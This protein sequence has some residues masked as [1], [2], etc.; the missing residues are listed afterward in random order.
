MNRIALTAALSGLA[1]VSSANAAFN[2][3]GAQIVETFD[4]L[5]LSTVTGVFSATAGTQSVVNGTGFDGTRLGGTGTAT[6]D[7]TASDGSANSGGIY[8]FGAASASERALGTI[9]SGTNFM[10]FGFQLTNGTTDNI[11]TVSVRF[12]QENWRSSTSEVNTT[13]ASYSTTAAASTY[14]TTGTFTPAPLLDLVGP[15][16]VTTNGLLDGNL[17]ANQVARA[18]TITG[19]SIA[20]GASI[21]F[22]WQD[23]NNA[24]S[25]AGLAIDA[26]T[27]NATTVPVPEPTTLA[28]IVGVGL[29]AMRRRRA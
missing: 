11:N 5:P 2:F 29:V 22:R 16:S 19:L 20:P 1:L 10:G 6:V 25:D 17:A 18:A 24:G 23:A 7:L 9:A 28:A 26:L 13:P 21:F 3:T 4:N 14:I 27:I 8:S 15:A 12:T